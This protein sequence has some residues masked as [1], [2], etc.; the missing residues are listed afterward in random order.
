VKVERFN[1]NFAT[2]S[3]IC[4]SSRYQK[5]KF[6][7]QN[8]LNLANAH[9]QL[10]N[11]SQ[12]N[13]GAPLKRRRERRRTG[14]PLLK[15]QIRH[16]LY[17]IHRTADEARLTSAEKCSSCHLPNQTHQVMNYVRRIGYTLLYFRMLIWS[18]GCCNGVFV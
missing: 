1:S 3:Y 11:F 9:L 8:V 13:P 4:K 14:G 18:L 17:G 7:L 10:H 16:L 6:G 12:G 5:V 2:F 15:F